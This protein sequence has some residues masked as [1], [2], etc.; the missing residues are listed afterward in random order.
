MKWELHPKASNLS[1]KLYVLRLRHGALAVYRRV[2]GQWTVADRARQCREASRSLRFNEHGPR[3][4][5][6][7]GRESPR[8]EWMSWRRSMI[9]YA[10]PGWM[11]FKHG[12][13]PPLVGRTRLY[14]CAAPVSRP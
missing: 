9:S 10:F 1:R 8:E 11:R 13:A 3:W 2:K 7:E 6:P 12:K 4:L 14:D 5:P